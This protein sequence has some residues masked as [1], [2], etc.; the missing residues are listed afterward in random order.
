MGKHAP[1]RSQIVFTEVVEQQLQRLD[2]ASFA[3][4][5]LVLNVVAVNPMVGALMERAPTLR[6]Y[7]EAGCR[8]VYFATTLG[9]VVVVAYVEA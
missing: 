3:R 7:G 2:A 6:E 9:T 1:R 8:V 5:E 4:L